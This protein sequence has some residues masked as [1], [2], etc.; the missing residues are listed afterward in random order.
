MQPFS[1]ILIAVKL[2]A[3]S[4]EIRT[5]DMTVVFNSKMA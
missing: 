1:Y 2:A 5:Y 3:W 4:V